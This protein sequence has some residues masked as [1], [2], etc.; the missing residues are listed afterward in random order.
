M[1]PVVG[2]EWDV[3]AVDDGMGTNV[4][5][6]TGGVEWWEVGALVVLLLLLLLLLLLEVEEAILVC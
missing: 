5:H 4:A 1:V 2:G 3:V 6:V